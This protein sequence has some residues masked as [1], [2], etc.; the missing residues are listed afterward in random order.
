MG[1]FGSLYTG[2][3][4]MLSQTRSTG[5]ISQNIANVTTVGYKRSEAAFSEIVGSGRRFSPKN[6]SGSVTVDRLQRV[7]QQGAIFQ[8]AYGTDAAINGNGFFAVRTADNPNAPF[9]FTRNGSFGEDANG[10][11]RNAAGFILYGAAVSGGTVPDVSSGAALEPVDVS[12]FDETAIPSSFLEIAMNLDQRTDDINPH[13]LF[14][15]QQ[16][17]VNN[18][19]A[20]FVRSFGVVDGFGN[21]Q[22][23]RFEFRKIVGPMANFTSNVSSQMALTDSLTD[24]DGPTPGIATNS[25]FSVTV[26]AT[27]ET[28]EIV[29]TPGTATPG[30]IE[31]LTVDDLIDAYNNFGGGGLVEARLNNGQILVQGVDPASTISLSDGVGSPLSGANTLN[32]VPD[33]GAESA[34]PDFTFE[35]E[36]SITGNSA[37]YPN[38]TDFPAFTDTTDP[39]PHH[40]WEVSIMVDVPD[41][42]NPGSFIATEISRGMLNFNGDGTMNA[43]SGEI[44]IATPIDFDTSESGEEI[45]LTI[46]IDRVSQ[47]ASDTSVIFANT[48]GVP[49]GLRTDVEISR[50]GYVVANYSNGQS[51]RLYRI[52]IVTFNNPDGLQD[53]SG[54]VFSETFYS[55]TPSFQGAGENG[56]GFLQTAS[57]EQSNVD[58]A[59]EFSGLIVSQRAYSLNSQVIQ[60]VSEM[61]QNLSQLVR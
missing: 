43:A 46:D 30:N 28:F 42:M 33:P 8:S 38:Q 21:Q 41:T 54:T 1:L 37:A 32:I 40:W 60:A 2:A 56:A 45:S 27:T 18:T 10:L 51:L 16:L 19:T 29:D 55:G 39:N 61:T 31:I 22:N 17:P 49:T 7:S 6:A 4:G 34:P 44:T 12:A 9:M 20:S 50:D 26:G 23:V 24:P 25:T 15:P 13:L 47:F 36:A 52:P 14:P 48:D 11:L 35:P 57:L 59:Q 3:A 5:Y 53:V 58:I